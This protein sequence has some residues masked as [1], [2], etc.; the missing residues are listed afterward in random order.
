[1]EIAIVNLKKVRLCQTQIMKL[2]IVLAINELKIRTAKLKSHRKLFLLLIFGLFLFWAIYMGP[3]LF[4]SIFPEIILAFSGV[5]E[6]VLHYII[7]YFLMI[8]FIMFILYPLFTLFRKSEIGVKD[9]LLSS[10]VKHGDIF[11]GD[12]LGQLPFIFLIVLG[13]GPAAVSLMGQVNP[14]LT[15]V[16]FIVIYSV[17]FLLMSFSLIIGTILANW[18]ELKISTNERIKASSNSYLLLLSFIVIIFFYIFHF[19]FNI[20]YHNPAFK[21]WMS[22]FPSFWY[23]NIILFIINPA[24]V[25]SYIVNIWFSLILAIG[26]PIIIFL[27]SYKKAETFYGF[28]PQLERNLVVKDHEGLFLKLIKKISLKKYRIAIIVQF[29]NFVRKRENI[30]K[31]VYSIAFTGVLGLFIFVSLDSPLTS[32]K[33]FLLGELVSIPV[34][35]FDILVLTIISWLGGLIFGMMMGISPII[36]SKDILNLY[37]KTSRGVNTLIFAFI[38]FMT[39]I[40]F[41]FA[42][43]LTIFFTILFSLNIATIVYFFSTYFIQSFIFL[44]QL[45]GIQCLRPLYGEKGKQIYFKIYF[46]GLLQ[47]ISLMISLFI[48]MPNF[49]VVIDYSFGFL[50]ILFINVGISGIIAIVLLFLGLLKLNRTD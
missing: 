24:L 28:E 1:M 33:N 22:I 36:D 41:F 39:Y 35:Y 25:E 30:T 31:L 32:I 12:F 34:E 40:L 4:D 5:L 46:I 49:P 50:H 47:V 7:E 37:K 2:W 6:I 16:H 21:D 20:G 45:V 27:V 3:I 44:I 11:L 10:P 15:I 42:I 48:T 8:V 13:V 9:I 14:Q 19:L 18:L 17:I 29:K 23:S 38:S 43:I 26:V